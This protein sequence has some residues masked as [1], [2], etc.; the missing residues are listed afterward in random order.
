LLAMMISMLAGEYFFSGSLNGS[1]N[2]VYLLGMMLGTAIVWLITSGP[3]K[4]WLYWA[5]LIS[6]V[7]FMPGATLGLV[8]YIATRFSIQ[9]TNSGYVTIYLLGALAMAVFYTRTASRAGRVGQINPPKLDE[10][11]QYHI[12]ISGFWAFLFLNVLIIGVL[13]QPWM[14]ASPIGLWITVLIAGLVFWVISLMIL[15]RKR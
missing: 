10:R 7:F 3:R 4:R 15:E 11:Y 5:G 13:L 12:G 14:T 1:L 9:I 6:W 8:R 2:V